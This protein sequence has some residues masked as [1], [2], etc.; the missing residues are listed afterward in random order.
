MAFFTAAQTDPNTTPTPASGYATLVVS[1]D[2]QLLIK[3]SAGVLRAFVSAVSNGDLLEG[4][5]ITPN[6]D[7]SFPG[8]GLI[9]HAGGKATSVDI[10]DMLAKSPTPTYTG[11]VLTRIDYANGSHKTF[12]YTAGLLTRIDFVRP[13]LS[14]IRKTLSYTDEVWTGT[15]ETK[16]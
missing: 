7:V 12:T 5:P 6:T 11:G 1:P 16:I 9:G 10:G 15:V 14:T 2:G 8:T 3:D 4:L 13:G